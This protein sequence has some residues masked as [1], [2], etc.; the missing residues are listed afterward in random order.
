MAFPVDT[1]SEILASV[2]TSAVVD[3]TVK[4]SLKFSFDENKFNVVDGNPITNADIEATK[5]WITLFFKTDINTVPIYKGK[6]F[7]TSARKLIG[8]KA[9]NNGFYESEVERETREGLPLCPTIKQVTSFN[10]TKSGKLLII[11]VTVELYDGTLLTQDE[12]IG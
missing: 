3:T 9:L 1:L 7:G 12:T 10:M 8:Y 11:S 6:K 4:T 2:K 5:Q